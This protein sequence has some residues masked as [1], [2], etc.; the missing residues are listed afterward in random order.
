MI[1][2]IQARDLILKLQKRDP[3]DQVVVVLDE[4]TF[5]SRSRKMKIKDLILILQSQ[6]KVVEA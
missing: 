5:L 6:V 2:K 3:E 1:F 4:N